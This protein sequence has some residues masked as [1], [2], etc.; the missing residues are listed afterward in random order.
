MAEWR[1]SAMRTRTVRTRLRAS[2]ASATI[3]PSATTGPSQRRTFDVRVS[4]SS[5]PMPPPATAT[6]TAAG[7]IM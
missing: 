1:E 7:S 2:G 5:Q 6:I 3:R 4:A